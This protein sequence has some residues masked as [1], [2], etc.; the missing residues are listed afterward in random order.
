M[1]RKQF[2]DAL[3]TENVKLKTDDFRKYC[4]ILYNF[5][6]TNNVDE[7]TANEVKSSLKWFQVRLIKRLNEN[8]RKIELV[9][10]KYADWFNGPII[11][12][13]IENK[14]Q[15][16]K[17]DIDYTPGPGRPS[18]SFENL[19]Q[20]SKSRFTQDIRQ[21]YSSNQLM[22]AAESSLRNSNETQKANI[23]KAASVSSP[24]TLNRITNTIKKSNNEAHEMCADAALALMLD[25]DL[26]VDKYHHLRAVS[27]QYGHSMYPSYHQV[28]S[29]KKKTYPNLEAISE[30]EV[31]VNLQ[32]LLDLTT[33]RFLNIYNSSDLACF[34]SLEFV[35]KYGMDGASGYSKY[36]QKSDNIDDGSLF[37]TSLVPLKLIG[38]LKGTNASKNIWT[39]KRPSSTRLCRPISLSF[40]KES[41]ELIVQENDTL[42]KDINN[43]NDTLIS[44]GHCSILVKYKLFF[45]MIDGKVF[46]VLGD[47]S[48]SQVCPI[49]NASPKDMNDLVASKKRAINK[50]MLYHGLSPLHS[51]IRFMECILH[52]SYRLKLK[53]W[54]VTGNGKEIL[55]QE[56]SRIQS[57][58]KEKL[59]LIIDVPADSGRGTSNDGNTARRFF[60]NHEVIAEVTGIDN[61]LLIR[62]SIILSTIN[63][64]FEINSSKFESYALETAKLYVAKYPWYYMPRTIHQVLIHGSQV[65][66]NMSIPIGVLSEEAQEARNKDNKHFRT[67]HTRKTSRLEGNEDLIHHLLVSSDPYIN[68]LR[69]SPKTIKNSSLS[70]SVIDLLIEPEIE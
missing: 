40:K 46:Q 31:R 9:K 24:G 43:I 3:I 26:S 45:T 66:S 20:R 68:S 38:F 62:F 59:G 13:E 5:Y 6:S 23:V 28:L 29:A 67:S 70:K 51:Y 42:K 12:E 63:C 41:A 15:E 55:N 69:K 7:N 65:I 11:S 4:H 48:S 16:N 50:D 49:C 58:L 21:K 22:S 25:L 47:I 33:E 10:I 53:K 34:D 36:K 17:M 61:E 64:S 27:L 8:Q 39:N 54:R 35:F 19:N 56:K 57:T 60:E 18:G 32:S 1:T 37:A 52:I 30:N 14:F 2:L 44:I